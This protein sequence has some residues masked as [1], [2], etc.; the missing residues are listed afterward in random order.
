MQFS[1][2]TEARERVSDIGHAETGRSGFD[3][4]IQIPIAR[5]KL[6]ILVHLNKD[7]DDA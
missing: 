7:R 6:D 3:L 1:I 4:D 5:A 2:L